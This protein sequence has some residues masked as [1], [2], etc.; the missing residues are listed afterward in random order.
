MGYN[1]LPG[2]QVSTNDG[3][4]A[5][6]STATAKPTVILGTAGAGQLST[7]YLVTDR[8]AAAAEFGLSGT[9]I[10][11]MEEVRQGGCDNIILF[12]IGARAAT[13]TG[14]GT[15]QVD[16]GSGTFA[17][18]VNNVGFSITFGNITPTISNDY[19]VYYESGLLE[20]WYQG[21]Q[22]YS[23]D[24]NNPI[25][26]GDIAVTGKAVAGLALK[27]TVYAGSV[28]FLKSIPLSNSLIASSSLTNVAASGGAITAI[29]VATPGSGYSSAPT[30]AISGGGG[31]GATATA[32]L[33][34]GGASGTVVTITVTAP[35]S[36]YTSNP[37]VT[38]SGGG[39]TVAATVGTVTKSPI[40]AA[41]RLPALVQDL[42]DT[43][44]GL[45][46]GSN[47]FDPCK[48][49][50]ALQDAYDLLEI[51]PVQQVFCPNIAIDTPNVAYYVSGAPTTDANNPANG[52]ALGWLKSSLD[53]N[54]NK[55]YQW[56]HKTADSA[57]NVVSAQTF[58]SAT[59][60]LTKN[61]NEVSF[62]YQLA[63]FCAK[64]SRNQGGCIG[65]IGFNAPKNFKPSGLKTWIGT[66]PTYA[67]SP[68]FENQNLGNPATAGT[69]LLGTPI[70]VG[71]T[72]A[73][74]NANCKEVATQGYR[75]AGLFETVDANDATQM[76][77]YDDAVVI[78]GNG[79]KTDIGAYIHCVADF[80]LL[81]NSYATTY[82]GNLAGVTAG[83]CSSLDEK[84]ALTNK[85]LSSVAQIYRLSMPQMDNL[86][87]AKINVLRF[88]GDN[89]PVVL[90]H[91]RS[92]A[93]LTSDY[94]FLL[95]L[96]I[97]FLVT[98]VLFRQADN[99]IGTSSTDGLTMAA[100]QT[101]L[102][103]DLLNL[104]KRG[105]LR[106]YNF[107]VSSTLASQR[108]GQM[109]INIVFSPANELVRISATVS[110]G[111]Q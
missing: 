51:M 91:D 44:L 106:G 71:T 6:G 69:G 84:A 93:L 4:L 37:T 55:V 27:D 12:R 50:E 22:V 17:A 45:T 20:V 58:T 89:N 80:A 10:Q 73:K 94:T 13:L 99:Y 26:T 59:D 36:G 67:G 98:S 39:F 48:L 109:F 30:V 72:A 21:N 79:Y 110:A 81:S 82:V 97:K 25:D 23:N 49:Y 64:Q 90:L 75:L 15:L 61:F 96:R 7:P 103:K 34:S 62:G 28:H 31:T 66:M 86:V 74:L 14:I 100:L 63:R 38:L 11:G 108:V 56:A 19:R 32:A 105:Y 87:Q 5:I 29:A 76:G 8:A 9:L 54:N 85:A 42:G 57:G 104:Q 78:D 47:G 107:T 3:G 101:A 65:F 43:G 70:L 95:R 111:V 102:D 24:V 33:G 92:A 52:S 40:V 41:T 53:V 16:Q 35:G 77:D 60:R 2:V 1:Y 68:N 88:K 83:L 18:D 46:P